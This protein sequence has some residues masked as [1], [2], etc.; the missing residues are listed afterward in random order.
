MNYIEL[1]KILSQKKQG[2]Y[3]PVVYQTVM[4]SNKDHKEVKVTK[5]VKA[6]VRYGIT[7]GNIGEVKVKKASDI[8]LG[9]TDDKTDRELPW[10]T[11]INRWIIENHGNYYVRMT[12]SKN[13]LHHPKVLGYYA[14]G[15]EITEDQA[16]ALTRP[17][18]WNKGDRDMLVFNKKIGDI[19]SL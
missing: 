7:Y 11:W 15:V 9:I 1:T 4:A 2:C 19:L 3:Y 16:R 10:G 13:R 18:E 8:L 6:I 17:S 5:V 14:D 12:V